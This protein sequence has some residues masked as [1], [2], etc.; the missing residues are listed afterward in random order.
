MYARFKR[1]FYSNL[2]LKKKVKSSFYQK[3]FY[4]HIKS[5]KVRIHTTDY[6]TD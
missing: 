2:K 3:L 6:T 1:I 4:F 5:I